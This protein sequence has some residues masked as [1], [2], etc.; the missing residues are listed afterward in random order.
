[1]YEA[2][3]EGL[4]ALAFIADAA[5]D[6]DRIREDLAA[7]GITAVIPS[8]PTRKAPLEYDQKLYALRYHVECFF[9]DLKRFR[10]VATRYEKRAYTFLG[11]VQLAC[12]TLLLN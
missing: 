3:S 6:A 9:H 1:M 10:R 8:N 11:M 4:D 5:Y 12:I 7:R 2:A